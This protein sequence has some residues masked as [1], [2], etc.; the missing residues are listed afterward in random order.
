MAVAD[1]YDSMLTLRPYRP[2]MPPDTALEELTC[3]GGTEFDPRLI[4][5]FATLSPSIPPGL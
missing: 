5:I 2:A 1:A 4:L 3:G